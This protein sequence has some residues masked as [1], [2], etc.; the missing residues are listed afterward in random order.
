MP[1]PE[2]VAGEPGHGKLKPRKGSSRDAVARHQRDRIRRA[3]IELVAERGYDAVKVAELSARA[4]VSTRDFYLRCQGKQECLLDTHD[5][6]MKGATLRLKMAVEPGGGV[7]ERLRLALEELGDMLA[8]HP[9]EARFA[10]LDVPA[11]AGAAVLERERQAAEA[12]AALVGGCLERRPV[13]APLVHGIVAGLT[14]VVRSLLLDGREADFAGLVPELHGWAAVL[15]APEVSAFAGLA[16]PRRSADLAAAAGVFRLDTK[17]DPD[18]GRQGRDEWERREILSTTL[19]MAGEAGYW[20]LTVPRIRSAVGISRARFDAHYGGVE[21][22]YAAAIELIAGRL[23]DFTAGAA[24]SLGEEWPR[25]FHRAVTAL[26][27]YTA[28]EPMTARLGLV[29]ILATGRTGLR[30]LSDLTRDIAGRLRA[31]LPSADRPPPAVTE[32]STGAVF[33][34]VRRAIVTRRANRLVV[35]APYFSYLALAPAIGPTA[36]LAA[37]RTESGGGHGHAQQRPSSS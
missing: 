19:A 13:P 1:E 5:W 28:R 22:A 4:G 24:V 7:G 32:A 35:L 20:Q 16:R 8:D 15:S 18:G 37:I 14:Q 10:F 23:A 33:T 12:L 30:E 36:A 29:E 3:M 26:C 9:A 34:L 17:F 31:E 6:L 21:G 2:P 27:A 11:A 25:G